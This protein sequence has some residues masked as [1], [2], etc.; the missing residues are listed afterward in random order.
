MSSLFE[1]EDAYYICP[2]VTKTQ[3]SYKV[4]HEKTQVAKHHLLRAEPVIGNS[5]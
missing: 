2:Y 5:A 1:T 3:E 4:L